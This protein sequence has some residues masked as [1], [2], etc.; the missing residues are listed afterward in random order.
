MTNE[1]AIRRILDHKRVHSL[2]E[3]RAVLINEA[4][5]L[6]INALRKEIA[7]EE[8]D[9]AMKEAR[10]ES[11]KLDDNEDTLKWKGTL[12]GG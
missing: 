2:N 9:E 3:P 7:K 1:E 10:R 11:Y 6:A 5:D 4:L 8:A 12:G